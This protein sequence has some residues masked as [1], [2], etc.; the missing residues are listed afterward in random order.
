MLVSNKK[1]WIRFTYY[2]MNEPQIKAKSLQ[3]RHTQNLPFSLL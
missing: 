3:S 1:K 2:E